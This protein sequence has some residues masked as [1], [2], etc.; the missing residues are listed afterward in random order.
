MAQQKVISEQAKPTQL[1]IVQLEEVLNLVGKL[2]NDLLANKKEVAN[3]LVNSIE[4]LKKTLSLDLVDPENK[5]NINNAMD[6]LRRTLELMQDGHQKSPDLTS[7]T[8]TVA[9]MLAV[10]YPVLKNLE[11]PAKAPERPSKT[12][13]DSPFLERRTAPRTEIEADIGFQSETNFFMGFT[14]DISTGGLFIATYDIRPLG[15]SLCVNF[16]LPN[17]HLVSGV[18]IVRW[19]R[20]YNETTPDTPPGMGIQFEGLPESDKEAIHSFIEERPAIFYDDD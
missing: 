11:N 20:E 7:A 19:L 8:E 9:K 1:A 4:A 15:T 2:D 12:A 6:Y 18:G 10:L 3:T 17:G 16:T 5:K 14:E 13:P